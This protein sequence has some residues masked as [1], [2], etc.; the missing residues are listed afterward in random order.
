ML[1]KN[2]KP[3]T[4]KWLKRGA[5]VIFGIEA[6]AFAASYG[7]WYQVNTNRDTR[8]YLRDNYPS[9]L[10]YYYKTG[11]FIDSSSNIRQIDSA[12]WNAN[13]KF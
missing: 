2:P 4:R 1:V 12:Y 5:L 6:V 11:E 8:K 13:K 3:S 10:E 7:L 9:V